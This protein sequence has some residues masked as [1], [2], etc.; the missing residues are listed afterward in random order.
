MRNNEEAN[1]TI[2]LCKLLEF[3]KFQGMTLIAGEDGL[4]KLVRRCTLLEYQ[5]HPEMKSKYYYTSFG[6][7]DMVFTTFMYAV[8]N[9]HLIVDAIKRLYSLEVAA[10]V[11]KNVF[12]IRLPESFLRFANNFRIPVFL[13]DDI[14]ENQF[15]N[16][17]L[18]LDDALNI[19][20]NTTMQNVSIDE[21]LNQELDD[22]AIE[23]YAYRLFPSINKDFRIDY[24]RLAEPA[25]EDIWI[26]V[27]SIIAKA[28]P[29]KSS[30]RYKNGIFLFHSLYSDNWSQIAENTDPAIQSIR[31]L[32]D[33]WIIGIGWIH[34]KVSAF[35]HGIEEAYRASLLLKFP[36]S[37]RFS[38]MGIYRIL[39]VADDY[40]VR[41]FCNDT[42][43]PIINYDENENGKL[44]QTL[45]GL[46]QCQG[47]IR[48]LASDLGQHENTIRQR[49]KKIEDLTGL[50]YRNPDHYEQLS[51]A[52]KIRNY[53]GDTT[54]RAYNMPI[55]F[56]NSP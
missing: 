4:D 19:K 49:L 22:H 3:S 29:E 27:E 21:L 53:L 33:Q 6:E 20:T 34:H 25:E 46:I 26:Q 28:S 18:A 41:E 39:D 51:I 50:N 45:F 2:S 44:S 17:V 16:F 11:I 32:S 8:D 14:P 42:L 48:R 38:D 55:N 52:V 10:I 37:M 15:H 5:F 36:G 24:Y 47:D 31:A 7:G 35:K 1:R 23:R 30:C 13:V 54:K 12:H 56:K 40:R 9:E 43:Q